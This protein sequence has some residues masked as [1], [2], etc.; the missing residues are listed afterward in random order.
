MV[1]M[2]ALLACLLSLILMVGSVASAVARHQAAGMTDVALC[3]TDGVV[4]VLQIDA[5][6]NPVTRGHAC[7]H[8]LAAPVIGVLPQVPAAAGPVRVGSH[9]LPELASAQP[10]AQTFSPLARG[11]PLAV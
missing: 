11:P 8:C 4:T 7:P 1:P 9:V 6:G 2:R 10:V 3:G 5:S